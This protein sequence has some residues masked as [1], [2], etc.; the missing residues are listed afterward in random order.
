[1]DKSLSKTNLIINADDFGKNQSVNKAITEC[2]NR[3]IINRT[4]IMMNMPY[5]ADALELSQKNGFFEHIGIHLNLTEGTPLTDPIKSNPNFC[6]ENGIFNAAFYHN[7][8]LRLKM[9]DKSVRDIERELDAQL[10]L[11]KEFG[12]TLNHVDSHHHAHTNFPVYKALEDLY[13]KYEFKSIRI[14]RNLYK[15][16]NFLKN[17]YKKYYNNKIR[18]ICD[19][20]T[21]Y[22]GSYR[23]VVTYFIYP[24]DINFRENFNDFLKNNSLEVMVHPCYDEK[25]VLSDIS[26]DM[27][28]PFEKEIELYEAYKK[29]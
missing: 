21:D 3:H 15:D 17:T 28:I 16:G 7:T 29:V 23:D 6:D 19:E 18:K 14:S 20:T 11:Y 24:N 8:R 22:F 1:M 4:T 5:V 9:D 25:G 26:G 10:S 12:F 2:F 27:Y 13:L